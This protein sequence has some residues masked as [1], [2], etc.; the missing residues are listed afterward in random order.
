MRRLMLGGS[1]LLAAA[2]GAYEGFQYYTL[3]PFHYH[4]RRRVSQGRLHGGRAPKG[5][6]IY[7]EVLVTDN[8]HVKAGR[9][10]R[11]STIA[12]SSRGV[13]GSR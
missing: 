13:A 3:G 5:L 10:S 7:H 6:R 2:Y 1:I 12:T 11:G 9:S 4:D 8:E